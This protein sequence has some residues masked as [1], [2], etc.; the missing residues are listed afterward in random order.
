LKSSSV[1]RSRC[2]IYTRVSTEHGLDQGQL[3][4]C[5]VRCCVSLHKEAGSCRLGQV[6]PWR[7]PSGRGSLFYLLRNR[8]YVGEVKYKDEI[9][10]GEQPAIM[11][12]ALFDAGASKAELGEQWRRSRR[13]NARSLCDP[14][15]RRSPVDRLARP[16]HKA[17]V[18]GIGQTHDPH[19]P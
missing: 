16:P 11:D 3:A 10:P 13:R 4:R 15:T 9:L 8:F 18:G 5:P 19:A 7:A 14:T 17:G 12:R 1:K 2:A 6:R